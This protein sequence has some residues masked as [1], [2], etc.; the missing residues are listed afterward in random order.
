MIISLIVSKFFTLTTKMNFL[1]S[2]ALGSNN[3]V[4]KM[5]ELTVTAAIVVSTIF[6]VVQTAQAL[7]YS[8]HTSY[9]PTITSIDEEPSIPI[10]KFNSPSK[11]I[12]QYD[13]PTQESIPDITEQESIPDTTDYV[14][15]PKIQAAMKGFKGS[16][17]VTDSTGNILASVG[18]DK[19]LPPASVSKLFTTAAAL[20]TYPANDP[21]SIINSKNI[22]ALK[23]ANSTSNNVYFENLANRI[24]I[25]NVQKI[26]RRI[27]DNNKVVI[28]NGSGCNGKTR[29]TSAHNCGG[30][31]KSGRVTKISVSDTVK[32]IQYLHDKLDLEGKK[33]ED[34]MG[35]NFD[36]K[37]TL[38][39]R[40]KNNIKH[41]VTGKTGTLKG[42]Y[43]LAGVMYGPNNA[44]IYF[45]VV[46][47]S[48]KW[49][50]IKRQTEVLN[51]AFDY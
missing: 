12:V 19:L 31:S 37:S 13:L 40:Y 8:E 16:F 5:I 48:G 11:E 36:G 1:T 38:A 51:A 22:A 3:P 43:S 10:V 29:G 42:L 4:C 50:A 34:V 47:S 9:I 25:D 17:V 7:P 33:M 14:N 15:P 39:S 32:V 20:E 21:R 30:R 23:K 6:S 44:A 18:K 27:T 26:I 2:L 35:T 49:L 28:G 41:N 45:A 46:S 24:G